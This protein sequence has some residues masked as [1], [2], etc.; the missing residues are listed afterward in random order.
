ML[1]DEPFFQGA[2]PYLEQ[3][4]RASG[5]PCLRKD[6]ILDPYQIAEARAWGADAILLIAAALD[7]Q[8]LEELNDEAHRWGL[9]VLCEV[10]TRKELDRVKHLDCECFGVNNRDL[11]TFEVSLQTSLDLVA[12]LP[13][14]A[15]KIAE[16]GL[17][18]SADILRL[19]GA[20]F[21]AFLIG[22]SLMRKSD[23]GEALRDLLAP[24]RPVRG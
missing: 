21:D 11:V 18:G 8:Q 3:A 13:K 2:L 5:L 15:V 9:D 4:S 20:G 22:E 16:S 17:H 7:D 6:F 19:H 10:H 12:E 1:T 24:T 14:K 23:P